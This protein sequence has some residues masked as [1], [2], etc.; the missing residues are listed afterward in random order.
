MVSAM[1]MEQQDL[2]KAEYT[3]EI[4]GKIRCTVMVLSLSLVATNTRANSLMTRSMATVF[5]CSLTAT[6][7]MATMLTIRNTVTEFIIGLMAQLTQGCGTKT[8]SMVKE[9]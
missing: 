5:S 2:P 6:F 1:G 7:M 4:G 9:R 3:K 8:G